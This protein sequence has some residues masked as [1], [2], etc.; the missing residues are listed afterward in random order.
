MS[1][2]K[3]LIVK[4]LIGIPCS[5][6]STWSEDYVKKNSSWAR[7]NRDD[8]RFMLKDA[9]MCEPKVENLISDLVDNAIMTLLNKNMNVIV[10]ATN[11]KASYINH[12]ID[13][14]RTTADV[15]FQIFDIS[16]KKAMERMANRDRKVPLDV[17]ERMFE[18]YKIL[19]DSFDFT[20]RRKQP[21]IYR[22]PV[23]DPNK[24]SVILSDLDGTL[25]Q[26]N[27]K[28][29]P[30]DW[31]R[32]YVDDLDEIVAERI[33]MHHKMGEKVILVSGR[34]GSCRK[35]TEEALALHEIPY[36]ELHM[37]PAND[38]RKDNIIKQEILDREIKPRFNVK[39]VYDDRDQV[40]KMWRAN[41]IKCFQVQEGLF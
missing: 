11:L 25:F 36:F 30:F 28:R 20:T 14:V 16:I 41:G 2:D 34:D 27:G 39:F 21:R 17:V 13:L 10:D 7:V 1:K 24:E 37:R 33:R 22:N 26:M 19:M 40:V 23:F 5:G 4:I 12:F 15:E 6:K 35:E 8:F 38:F 32:V 31:K 29:G 3:K 18:Q 9:A